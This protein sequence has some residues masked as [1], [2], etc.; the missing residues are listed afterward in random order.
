VFQWEDPRAIELLDRA[1]NTFD[2]QQQYRLYEDLHRLMKED[3]PII[4][5]YNAHSATAV[6]N[7]V[8]G[9]QAWPLNLSRAWGV[10]KSESGSSR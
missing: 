5:L 8:E 4:G 1:I 3:V 9:Y 10:W 7:A 6:L 2:E